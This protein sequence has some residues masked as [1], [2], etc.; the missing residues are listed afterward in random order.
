MNAL[1]HVGNFDEFVGLIESV[2]SK[3]VAE[4]DPEIAFLVRMIQ[5]NKG[6]SDAGIRAVLYVMIE[7]KAI[8]AIACPLG[9]AI[10]W[11]P[12]A[13]RVEPSQIARLIALD[14]VTKTAALFPPHQ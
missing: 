1:A 12:K 4:T 6:F 10:R 5:S 14:V 8:E 3:L 11:N 13:K 9:T 2:L 7:S